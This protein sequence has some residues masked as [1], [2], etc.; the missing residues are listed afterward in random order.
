MKK[1]FKIT[2]NSKAKECKKSNANC[3]IVVNFVFC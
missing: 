1:S 2:A 3:L